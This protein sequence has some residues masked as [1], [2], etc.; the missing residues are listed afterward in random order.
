MAACFLAS[1]AASLAAC[2]NPRKVSGKLT[3]SSRKAPRGKRQSSQKA[4][5]RIVTREGNEWRSAC[6]EGAGAEWSRWSGAEWRRMDAEVSSALC[7]AD[8]LSKERPLGE[9]ADVDDASVRLGIGVELAPQDY[10]QR[11]VEIALLRV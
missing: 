7:R 6:G 11:I 9:G 1:L 2:A 5:E 10:V 4:E 3:R 8:L